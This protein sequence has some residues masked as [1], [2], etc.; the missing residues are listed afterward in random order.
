MVDFVPHVDVTKLPVLGGGSGQDSQLP[1]QMG[2]AA[3]PRILPN[4]VPAQ[5]RVVTHHQMEPPPQGRRGR[6][7]QAEYDLTEI[8]KA[9]DTDGLLRRASDAHITCIMKDGWELF[10]RNDT[11]KAYIQRRLDEI[12]FMSQQ[13][14]EQVVREAAQNLVDYHN[15]FV[16][17]VRNPK[18]SSGRE[19]RFHGKRKD[20]IAA[21]HTIDPTSLF[22][23]LGDTVEIRSWH[24]F[25]D[26]RRVSG[27]RLYLPMHTKGS[28]R[29]NVEDIVHGYMRRRAGFVFGTPMQVPVLDDIRAL[30][31]LE[32]IAELIAHRHA[33]PLVHLQ[34]GTEKIPVK[35]LPGGITEVDVVQ[36]QYDKV[37]LEGAFVTSERVTVTPIK[38]DPMELDN[39]LAHYEKRALTGLGM[40]EVD[41]G[42][43]DTANRGTAVVMSKSLMDR[44]REYQKA[45]MMFFTWQVFDVLLMEGGFTLTP[46]NRVFMVFPEVDL[47]RRMAVN[48]HALALYQ[49]GLITETE[50]RLQMGRDPITTAQRKDMHFERLDKPLS[51]IKAVDEPY[52]QAAKNA[53]TN[54]NQP[55]NQNGTKSSKGTPTNTR[56]RGDSMRALTQGLRDDIFG[57]LESR[58]TD[59]KAIDAPQLQQCIQTHRDKIADQLVAGCV[60]KIRDGFK[61]YTVDS[62]TPTSF[63]V[64]EPLKNR[65]RKRCVGPALE[66]FLGDA[67]SDAQRLIRDLCERTG[68]HYLSVSAFFQTWDAHW[69]LMLK[70]LDR[71]AERFGYMQAVDIDDAYEVRW[72]VQD[73]CGQ[74]Q[75]FDG[76]T[77]TPRHVNYHGLGDRDCAAAFQLV[78]TSRLPAR[79]PLLVERYTSDGLL[80]LRVPERDDYLDLDHPNRFLKIFLDSQEAA[81]LP[82]EDAG[83]WQYKGSGT[84]QLPKYESGVAV[85]WSDDREVGRVRFEAMNGGQ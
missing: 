10:G 19:I 73:P 64:G 12:S 75:E 82:E 79:V 23:L 2:V 43:G 83:G 72:K 18:R 34:V 21:V 45:L 15:F 59:G 17:L 25:I 74:C 28:K 33:F 52:T 80:Q 85:L 31:R 1:T 76:K 42:R 66:R 48:N 35:K 67:D 62:R 77:V 32:E 6:I 56:I 27:R 16:W 49:G 5:F 3:R 47:D 11:A 22:P 30:R 50:A 53:A 44:C 14:F 60:P 46:E 61:A 13:P 38:L 4:V 7:V 57:Y 65:F 37:P 68:D 26:G 24:Q 29:Y 8:A 58:F 9:I 84:V 69:A 40:S 20:P 63:F 78:E 71:V 55:T 51:I 39:L 81:V 41:I 36:R 70:R 54:R